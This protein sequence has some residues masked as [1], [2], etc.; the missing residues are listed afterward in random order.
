MLLLLE[1]IIVKCILV[2]EKDIQIPRI[3]IRIRRYFDS[4]II[5]TNNCFRG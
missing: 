1:N 3:T 2:V 4:L 5:V